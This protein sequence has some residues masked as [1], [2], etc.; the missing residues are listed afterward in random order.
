MYDRRTEALL[1]P[2][3]FRRVCAEFAMH[4]FKKI[5]CR[6]VDAFPRLLLYFVVFKTK[7]KNTRKI[8]LIHTRN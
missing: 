3:P 4:P 1:I 2:Q 5:Y 8:K 6:I 7:Q